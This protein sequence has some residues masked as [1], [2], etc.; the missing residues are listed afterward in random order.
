MGVGQEKGLFGVGKGEGIGYWI[1]R[2][3][4]SGIDISQRWIILA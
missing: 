2:V 4:L 3:G 1:F